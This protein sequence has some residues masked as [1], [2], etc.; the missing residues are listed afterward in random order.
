LFTRYAER[1][2]SGLHILVKEA[3]L[4][5]SGIRIIFTLLKRIAEFP[6]N[7]GACIGGVECLNY[8]LKDDQE[9]LW[10]LSLQLFPELLATL[11]AFAL[12]SNRAASATAL[13]HLSDLVP[14]F[15]RSAGSSSP[16]GRWQPLWVP[17]LH[18]LSH[19]ASEGQQRTSAQAF[20]YLQRM[21]L[22]QGTDLSLPWGELPFSAWKEC[23]EQVL[24]PLLKVQH[25]NNSNA[26]EDVVEERQANAAQ[27]LCRVVLT[28]L[29][30][31]MISA[32]ESFPG[33]HLRLLH[34]LVSEPVTSNHSG[35]CLVEIIKNFL[36][37][38]SADPMFGKLSSQN[39]ESLIEA[40]WGVVSPLLPNLRHEIQ[41]ILD[42]ESAEQFHKRN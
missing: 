18:V 9:L 37:V 27:L 12:Q 26:S 40:T 8:W 28:H 4:P 10:L 22:E 38:I 33:L 15:V 2:A 7:S 25:S 41:L 21:L 39:G 14:R 1:M 16:P 34:V 42:P 5:H 13:S 35:E 23:L 20:V 30:E 11:E 31:W 3:N 24:F 6:T 32:P 36:L 29:P 17:T 19:I